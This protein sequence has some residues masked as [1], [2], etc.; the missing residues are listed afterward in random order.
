M[1]EKTV[2][3]PEGIEARQEGSSVTIKGPKG[4]LSRDFAHPKVSTETSGSA[5]RFKS[6]DD[7]KRTVALLGTFAAHVRNMITGV[8][9][10]WECRLKVVYSHFPVKVAVEGDGVAIQNFMGGRKPKKSMIVGQT[11]VDV[12]KDEIVV[13]GADKEDVGQTAANME[14]VTKVAKFDKRIFQDGI[15]ITRKCSPIETENKN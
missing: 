4:E 3:I 10:G 11:K 8:K 6:L 2:E 1:A 7:R 13:T 5:V 15:Y 12:N 14:L 9:S